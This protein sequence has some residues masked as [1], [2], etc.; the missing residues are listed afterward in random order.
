MRVPHETP[1]CRSAV[2][3]KHR[4]H[5]HHTRLNRNFVQADDSIAPTS[6]S[7]DRF[8]RR[9]SRHGSDFLALHSAPRRVSLLWEAVVAKL[10]HDSGQEVAVV[11]IWVVLPGFRSLG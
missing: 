8:V 3:P 5:L 11:V 4:L 2:L 6:S 9:A 1:I 7:S 10:L